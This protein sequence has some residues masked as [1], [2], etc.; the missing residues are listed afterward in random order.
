MNSNSTSATVIDSRIKDLKER[1]RFMREVARATERELKAARKLARAEKALFIAA[2]RAN[3]LEEA[4]RW[5][6]GR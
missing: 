3:D 2:L 5:K 4:R 6:T 1:L